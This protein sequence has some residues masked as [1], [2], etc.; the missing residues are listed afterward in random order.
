MTTEPTP[1]T[2]AEIFA[3]PPDQFT[4]GDERIKQAVAAFRGMRARFGAGDIQA[5]KTKRATPKSLQGVDLSDIG[6]VKL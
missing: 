5:G 6:D 3:T 4:K 2:L 1:D